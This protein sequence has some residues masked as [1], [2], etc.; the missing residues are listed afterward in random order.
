MSPFTNIRRFGSGLTPFWRFLK[1]RPSALF[2]LAA[3]VAFLVIALLDFVFPQY[4]GV[5]NALTI[6]SFSN[7]NLHPR[8]TPQPPSLDLGWKY[9]F[10]S[11]FYDLPILPVMLAS[12]GVDIEYSLFVIIVSASI[13]VM[14]GIASAYT[15]KR[16]DMLVMRGTD[17]FMS[18]PAIVAVILYSTVEGWNYLNISLGLII[19]WWTSYARLSRGATLPLRSYNF[20]EAAVASGSSK[21][22]TVFRHILPNIMSYIVVQVTLDLGM[23]ITIFASINFLFS[24]LNASDAFVPEIGD[25]MVGFPQAGVIVDPTYWGA[26]PPSTS[27]L[28]AA[29]SWWPIVIPGLFLVFFIVSVN[30]AGDG[31]R[32]Y[33]NPRTRDR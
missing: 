26:G 3:T 16:A 19:I 21:I 12:I 8:A 5:N 29:G 2:G 7:L 1:G 27:I 23:I 28:L 32:D 20:V 6:F 22:R 13:G 33:L 17:I 15:G 10:G 14:I 9:V 30:L 18:L 25:L 4:L 31:L 11:T 24:G